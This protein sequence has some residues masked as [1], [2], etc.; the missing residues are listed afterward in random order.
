MAVHFINISLMILLVAHFSVHVRAAV[1]TVPAVGEECFVE[2]VEANNKLVGSFEVISGGLLDIEATVRY[3][4]GGVLALTRFHEV[5][6][7]LS[8]LLYSLILHRKVVR[9][10]QR[11]AIRGRAAKVG[12]VQPRCAR[13]GSIPPML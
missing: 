8:S 11:S 5:L 6:T 4:C 3:L 1:T 2:V 13:S 7:T 10:G 9:T 12:R